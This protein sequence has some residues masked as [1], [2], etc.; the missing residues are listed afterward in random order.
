[1]HARVQKMNAVT[2]EIY[3]SH[4]GIC[5][6]VVLGVKSIGVFG[7]QYSVLYDKGFE[8]FILIVY[9]VFGL[10]VC[11]AVTETLMQDKKMYNAQQLHFSYVLIT[12]RY[13]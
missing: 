13:R 1:M 6:L 4:L 12:C 11:S 5:V 10:I 7:R 8:F 3:L 9:R 2:L